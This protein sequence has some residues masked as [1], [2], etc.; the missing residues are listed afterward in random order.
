MSPQAATML[1]LEGQHTIRY[2]NGPII[3]PGTSKTAPDYEVLANFRSEN[4]LYDIQKGTMTDK[5]AIVMSKFG[6]G[7]V[8]AF[9]PHFESTKGKESVVL[10]AIKRVASPPLTKPDLPSKS[11]QWTSPDVSAAPA[12]PAQWSASARPIPDQP[13]NFQIQV[14]LEIAPGWHTYAETTPESP[15]QPTELKLELPKQVTAVG[16]W[17]RPLA[18]PDV[19]NPRQMIYSGTVV[20]SHK[21]QIETKTNPVNVEVKVRYQVCDRQKCLPPATLKISVPLNK[22]P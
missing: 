1:G 8:V 17:Q 11:D 14:T 18:R 15:Y 20:F 13:G 7:Q 6:K 16:Q 2:Q 3:S 4:Y 12:Q 19:K 5:P 9:S 21:I 10:N 22:S